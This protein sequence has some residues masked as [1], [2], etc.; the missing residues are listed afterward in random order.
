GQYPLSVLA[1]TERAAAIYRRGTYGN[2]MTANP[3]ALDVACAVLGQL[4]PQLRENIRTQGA[5]AVESLRRLQDELGGAIT[6]VQGTGL[7]FSCALADGIKAYGAG[8]VE[9]WLR[10]HGLGVIHGG[11]NSLRFTPRFALDA[12]EVDLI[13]SLVRRALLAWQERCAR[14]GSGARAPGSAEHGG[15]E[16]TCG[17]RRSSRDHVVGR[18]RV[19][20]EARHLLGCRE[21]VQREPVD[22]AGVEEPVHLVA[23]GDERGLRHRLVGGELEQPSQ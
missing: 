2:T 12:A 15:G 14:A 10:E 23:R 20:D 6:H 3:R 11:E 1:L 8:S 9:E 16:L 7:L 13:V 22:L 17:E 5:Y 21:R 18:A 19:R 4:T